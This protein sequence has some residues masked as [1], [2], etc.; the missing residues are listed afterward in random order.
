MLMD[1]SNAN[2]VPDITEVLQT[3]RRNKVL[4]AK[5]TVVF[6]VIGFII[7]LMI[8][9]KYR[10]YA[11]LVLNEQALNINDFQSIMSGVGLDSMSVK[12]EAKILESAGLVEKTITEAD[13]IK[14]S[15][16]DWAETPRDAIGAF[17]GNLDIY[18]QN[19]SR[20]IE[21][22][23]TAKDP[24]L[25]AD[26]ANA[27][28][29]AYLNSQVEFKKAQIEKLSKWFEVKVKELKAD[30]IRKRQ[31]VQDYRVQHNL[32]VGKD[33]KELIYQQISDVAGQLVP[34]EVD[35]YGYQ[36]K[37]ING[38]DVGTS[39]DVMGSRLIQELK[40][41]AA[42]VAKDLSA[43]R[44]KYGPNHPDVKEAQ[45]RL[46]EIK[47]AIQKET[48]NIA[49]SMTQGQ[50]SSATQEAL[51]KSRLAGLSQEA[52]DMRDK[53][54]MLESLQVEADASK[55]ILDNFLKN[56]ETIQ[57]QVSF[58]W[59]D[60]TLVSPAITPAKPI[61]PGK[62]MLMMLVVVFSACLALGIMFAMELTRMGLK[63]FADI[64]KLSQ[65]PLGIIP[66]TANPLIA[67]RN[68]LQ[69]SY[70]EAIKRIYIAG[71]M[72]SK[73]RSILVTS[74]L[75]K[76]G[77]TS[78][79]ISMAHYIRSLGHSVLVIDADFLRPGLSFL[80]G[81]HNKPGLADVLVGEAYSHEV[82]DTGADGI[83]VIGAGNKSLYSPDL[84]KSG[85]LAEL[86]EELKHDYEY[87]LVDAGPMQA[88]SEPGI[89]ATQVDGIVVIAEWLKTPQGDLTNLFETLNTQKT[90]VLGVVLNKVDLDKYKVMSSGSDFL[91]PKAANAA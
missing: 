34:I 89:I 32:I 41:Q 5:L 64:R 26:V 59:A 30:A 68:V 44:A 7:V 33:D 23:F 36:A 6:A 57:S 3:I 88:D 74:A 53:M 67:I 76:E 86:I 39:T 35:K 85:Q 38:S 91:L 16:Y 17:Q 69:S 47:W 54:I 83:S 40:I 79:I 14:H 8:P 12:T 77:R 55:K 37:Q 72:N 10:A 21:V 27:H 29:N 15:E 84:L 19:S 43:L 1:K 22:A 61:A 78:F 13:L 82:L 31:A 2:P 25:A 42:T 20:A 48:Q 60:A 49:D 62:R 45:S 52:N 81:T 90:P 18:T 75:P 9:S 71:M 80:T 28:A 24:Q 51:L 4:L 46:G 73:A 87:V 66:L 63:N 56:Y 65:K 58:A 70:K 50:E 11:T